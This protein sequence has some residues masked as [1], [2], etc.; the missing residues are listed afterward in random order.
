MTDFRTLSYTSAHEI[1]PPPPPRG[2]I[3]TNTIIEI[4]SNP[5]TISHLINLCQ[6]Q[7]AQLLIG[8]CLGDSSTSLSLC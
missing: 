1:P 7:V 3:M 5:I 8:H 2:L 6:L 4:K